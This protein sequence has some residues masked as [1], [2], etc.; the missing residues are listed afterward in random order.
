[1]RPWVL[2]AA[3]GTVIATTPM[4]SQAARAD[5]DDKPA[6][7]A[8]AAKP[9]TKAAEPGLLEMDAR[10]QARLG[11][12]VV[13]LPSAYRSS[14]QTAFARGLDPGPLAQ[15]DSDLASAKAAAAAS[16]AEAART[17]TLASD[18]TVSK[19]TAETAES[20]ARQDALKL[21]LLRQRVGLEWGP[22]LGK[23]SDAA[24]GKLIADI[25]AG[26]AALV[27]LDSGQGLP[28]GVGGSVII[29]TDA[30]QS[31]PAHIL[32]PTRAA[33]PR[34]QSTGL[35][36]VVR[37]P[38]ALRMGSGAVAPAS[39]AT[40]AGVSGVTLPRAALLRSAGQTFV[41]VRRDPTHFEKRAVSGGIVEPDGLFVRT[42]FRPGEVVVTAG[43]SQLFAAQSGAGKDVD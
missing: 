11:V 19:Q 2:A 36:A 9:A 28:L 21:K 20:Q 3:L 14:T 39:V 38:A 40:G 41:Y 27:R 5:D 16:A 6:A 35:L 34:L 18:Q 15:L 24:R 12:A 26:R 17:K 31:E 13:A 43:A 42:G 32:G 10:T 8:G 1:M 7:K 25:V 22:G 33:D 23:L 37:G 4:L 30:N 29:E